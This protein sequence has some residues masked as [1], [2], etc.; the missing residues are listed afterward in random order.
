MDEIKQE[1]KQDSIAIKANA[2][3]KL[4]YVNFLKKKSIV[5]SNKLLVLAS[6][7]WL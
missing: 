1:L 5:K 2:V 4:I 6:N 7:A 3:T